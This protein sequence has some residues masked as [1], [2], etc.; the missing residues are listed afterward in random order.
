MK[1]AKRQ[2]KSQ[3]ENLAV[4][5]AENAQVKDE[6][7]ALISQAIDKNVPV[8]SLER[9]LAMRRELRAEKSKEEYDRSMAKFQASCPTIQKKKEVRNSSDAVVY[10]YAPIESIV[11]Q[12]KD[13]L[14]DNGFSYS[15]NMELQDSQVTV[16]VKVTHRA[17]HSEK[18][19]MTVPLGTRTNI[20]SQSQVVAAASTFAKRYAFCNAFGIL[21]GDEDTD[22]QPEKEEKKESK[23][24]LVTQPQMNLIFKLLN[25]KGY[26]EHELKIKYEIS[27]MKELTLDQASTIIDNLLKLPEKTVAKKTENLTDKDYEDFEKSMEK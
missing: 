21:T 19:C 15:T 5:T 1:P 10:R 7:T 16:C 18:T 17:G 27:S 20:M 8:E 9:L 13:Q 22:S 26:T 23:S 12:V 25:D 24:N 14:S 6:A 4:I 2:K 11:E 3:D